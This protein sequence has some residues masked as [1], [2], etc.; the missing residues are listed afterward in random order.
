[1]HM[2]NKIV[3][4]IDQSYT[5]TGISVC[6]DGKLLKVT[7]INFPKCKNKSE[8]RIYLADVLTKLLSNVTR[9][10]VS[11]IILCER[12]RTF[13]YNQSKEQDKQMFISTGYIKATGALIA[14]IVDTAYR[15][16]VPV[17]SVDTRSWKAQVV[18]SSKGSKADG[19]KLATVK[20][21]AS[22]GFNL[23][24]TNKKGT[25]VHDDDACDSACIAL[26]GFIKEDKQSLKQEA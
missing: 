19:N 21:V 17:Y 26:Y 5:R 11:C 25:I 18:G 10:C 24:T 15:F 8:K 3:I 23:S 16:G 20:H 6:A 14:T 9:K 4:G 7:S 12:I 1:M 22:L 2:Y 13:S